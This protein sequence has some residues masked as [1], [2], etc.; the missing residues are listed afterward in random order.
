MDVLAVGTVALDSIET[1][2]GKADDVLGGSATYIALA[3]RYFTPDVSIV[4]VV[5]RDFPDT[6]R[7]VLR[8]ARINLDGLETS[9]DELTFAWAGR[10]EFDLNQRETL[11]THL[12]ALSSFRPVISDRLCG[13]DIL[14]LG[15]LDP[16]IQHSVLDQVSGARF[17]VCDTMNYW[18]RETPD[19][20]R[21]ILPRIRCLVVNDSECRELADEPNLIRAARKIRDMGPDILVVKKGEHGALL[22]A[23]GTVFSVPA[24]PLEDIQDPTGAGDAFMGG[25]AGCLAG[26]EDITL[27]TLKQAVVFG[28]AIA[29]FSVEAFGPE[30]LLEIDGNDIRARIEAFRELTTIPESELSA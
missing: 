28:S 17:V 29:S 19:A 2:F 10:Y 20:L 9:A 15:N 5:G 21:R 16:V 22:F 4:A 23:D 27:S 3:A 14:C 11:A 18:I 7:Q 8:D 24:Y 1:P 12:N 13:S 6:Y 25:F 30:R 26:V